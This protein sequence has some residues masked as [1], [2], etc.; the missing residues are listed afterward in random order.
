MSAMMLEMTMKA[1]AENPSV[2][3][4]YPTGISRMSK[5]TF[6]A[7]SSA[8]TT[9]TTNRRRIGAK[10][11]QERSKRPRNL[12]RESRKRLEMPKKTRR[13]SPRSRGMI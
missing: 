11:T 4:S 5:A 3:M 2:E 6:L 8:S 1:A 9:F 12:R 13:K 10:S 7:P